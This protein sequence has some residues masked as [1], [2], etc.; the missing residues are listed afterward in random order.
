MVG[1]LVTCAVDFAALVRFVCFAAV[2]HSAVPDARSVDSL[3]KLA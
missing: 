1:R 3:S 2:Y